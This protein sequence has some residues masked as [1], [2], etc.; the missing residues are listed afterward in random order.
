MPEL[1]WRFTNWYTDA[2]ALHEIAADRFYSR[3][4]HFFLSILPSSD[5]A[6]YR[7]VRPHWLAGADAGELHSGEGPEPASLEGWDPGP[8]GLLYIG[9]TGGAEQSEGLAAT[10]LLPQCLH[11]LT[12]AWQTP[13]QVGATLWL[14]CQWGSIFI[15]YAKYSWYK[16]MLQC[17]LTMG[18]LKQRSHI[19]ES[20]VFMIIKHVSVA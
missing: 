15:D 3:L 19:V 5:L 10:G 16:V 13:A 1:P 4:F 18:H 8:V 12:N 14:T 7:R 11:S 6:F 9:P 20:E 17:I 2:V